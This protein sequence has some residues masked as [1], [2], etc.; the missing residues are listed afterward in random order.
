MWVAKL[1][2]SGTTIQWTKSLGGTDQDRANSVL[3]TASG[4]F[5]I[6]GYT[7]SSD[8][9]VTGWHGTAN[10]YFDYWIVKLNSAGTTVLWEKALGGTNDESAGEIIQ[11]NTG[12]YVAAGYSKSIDGDA[13]NNYGN[14]DVWL[15]KIS[16]A[17]GSLLW[18]KNY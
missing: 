3:Q 2:S 13:T 15:A 11:T 1:N 6:A 16:D 10:S 5:V 9:D 7:R 4:D 8:G 18:E 12:N 14:R 17:N